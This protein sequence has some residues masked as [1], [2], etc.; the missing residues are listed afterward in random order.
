VILLPLCT[1]LAALPVAEPPTDSFVLA[2]GSNAS[3]D[4]ELPPL[5]YA[6]DDAIR[7]VE[8]FRALGARSFLVTRPDENTRRV[9]PVLAAE[10]RLPL[11]ATLAHAIDEIAVA[12]VDARRLG[13]RTRLYFTFAG[14]GNLREGRA[15]LT[16][17]DG[18]LD[19]DWLRK[20]VERIGADESHLI[21]DACHATL[22]AYG[23]GPGGSH[24]AVHGF[25]VAAALTQDPHVG[26]LLSSSASGE[27]HEWEGFQ[28]GVFSHEVRSG[29]YGAADVDGD[30][31]VSYAEIAA[32]VAR[33]N[34]PIAN[35]RYRPDVF[36]RPAQ[37][38]S[39]LV[40]L[41]PAQAH[42][43]QLDGAE[44]S[45]HYLLED[46]RGVRVA[47]FHSAPG[48]ALSLVRPTAAPQLY[49]RR[50]DDQQELVLPPATEAPVV[51]SRLA[52]A[53]PR[54][55]ARGAAHEAFSLIF[56]LSFDRSVVVRYQ[57]APAR[58]SVVDAPPSTPAAWQRPVALGLG[59]LALTGGAFALQQGLH[60]RS[61]GQ[62][63]PANESQVA[64][65][66]RNDR[67]R[68]SR[69][70]AILLGVGG[71]LLAATAAGILLWSP[72]RPDLEL[73]AADDFAG[74]ALRW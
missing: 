59:A 5:R 61:L 47:D 65:G 4:T 53:A 29:L 54:E 70:N 62:D 19:G 43:I 52:A 33:A 31:R 44:K 60:A 38:H 45:A 23:R 1:L 66:G 41:R 71:A 55:S 26:L 35:E 12:V 57:A 67:I 50:L 58:V 27:A 21:V 20:L 48:Q 39:T 69:R 51:V 13:H 63:V 72:R 15:Y 17:E 7:Y 34:D 74:V 14:H 3:V 36:A 64:T 32:F 16:V 10:A 6:D 11:L 68:D 28:A 30:G 49:L 24:R 18:R 22:L 2:L 56:T 9:H 25:V 37:A 42:A 8:L 73:A 46:G 40:D